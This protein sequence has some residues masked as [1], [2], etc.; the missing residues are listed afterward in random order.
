METF[1][2]ME[3]ALIHYLFMKKLRWRVKIMMLV[4]CFMIVAVIMKD[5][6]FYV[7][8]LEIVIK[9]EIASIKRNQVHTGEEYEDESPQDVRGGF[10][11]CFEDVEEARRKATDFHGRKRAYTGW[12]VHEKT[13]GG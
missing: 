13:S 8:H 11:R 5:L 4:A 2:E 12:E 1:A 7:R 3:L 9:W 10:P 6:S